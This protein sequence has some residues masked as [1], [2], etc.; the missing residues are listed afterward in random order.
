MDLR[1]SGQHSPRTPKSHGKQS[2]EILK[3]QSGQQ[4]I[5][6]EC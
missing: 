5:E 2:N 6:K 1:C 3:I 4:R